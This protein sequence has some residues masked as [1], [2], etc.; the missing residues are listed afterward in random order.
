MGKTTESVRPLPCRE[1]GEVPEVEYSG[2]WCGVPRWVLDHECYPR[3]MHLEYIAEQPS[4]SWPWLIARWNA[5]QEA[6]H[7]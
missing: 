4:D 6:S 1:C 3:A 2:V 5:A 7:E